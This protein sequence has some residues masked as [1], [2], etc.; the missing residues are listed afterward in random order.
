MKIFITGATSSIGMH[1]IH[2]LIEQNHELHL[3]IRNGKNP[4]ISHPNVYYFEGDLEA[5]DVINKGMKNCDQVYHLAANANVWLK[6]PQLYFTTNVKGTINVLQAAFENGINKV[7][8]TSSAGS[9]GPSISSEVNEAKSREVDFFNEYESSK[10]IMELK[11]KEFVIEKKLDVVIVSPTRVYGP[12]L[13]GKNSSI[14]LLIEKFLFNNWRIIPGSGHEIGNYAFIKDVAKGHLLAMQN[15][16]SGNT[17]I[18]GGVNCSY[19]ELFNLLKISTKINRRMFTLPYWAQYLFASF[20]LF[21]AKIFTI[22]P[23]ITPKWIAKGI[24]DWEVNSTKAVK[25]LGYEITPLE[26]GIKATVDF[27][28]SKKH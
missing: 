5:I 24:F 8:V 6:N 13:H 4:P 12:I 21:F 14:T 20:Q 27:L 9:Y 28:K 17:Y 10:A 19:F 3:L 23:K 2:L 11:I 16:K 7:V 26:D 22:S 1:L 18:L 15:G 25:E